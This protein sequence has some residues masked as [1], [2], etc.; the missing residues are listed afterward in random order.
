MSGCSAVY[1]PSPKSVPLLKEK[2]EIQIEAG[3]S[4]NSIFTTGSYAFSEKYA[5]TA[6]GNLS[7]LNFLPMRDLGDLRP[8]P[9]DGQTIYIQGD[10]VVHRSIEAG[11]GRY[12]LLQASGRRLEIFAGAIYGEA[13]NY[14]LFQSK[15]LQGF[16]Q[17]NIDR[18]NKVNRNEG[19]LSFRIAFSNFDCIET[20]NN[21][22]YMPKHKNFNIFHVDYLFWFSKF[23]FDEHLKLNVRY[24]LN[25]AFYS[26]LGSSPFEI[27]N[28]D[29]GFSVLHLS[30]GL[31]YCF[32]T[33]NNAAKSNKENLYFLEK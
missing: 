17:A 9:S 4:T 10:E 15:Y 14:G 22:N 33:A 7:L 29:G 19:G 23:F 21:A 12:N 30:I 27:Y 18:K 26:P 16:L 6:N 11:L 5:L 1:I 8:P 2:G 3:L 25:L 31:S 20:S 32:K 24:G 28:Y 13:D